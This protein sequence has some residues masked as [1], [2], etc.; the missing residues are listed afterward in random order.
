MT[1]SENDL[2][3]RYDEQEQKLIVYRLSDNASL[4][5][6]KVLHTEYSLSKLKS[7]SINEAGRRIGED[8]LVSLAGTRKEVLKQ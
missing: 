3:I 1:I 7:M 6:A 8:I 5:C 4:Q 2:L